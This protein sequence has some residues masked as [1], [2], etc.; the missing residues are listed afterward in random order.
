MTHITCRLTA[1][2]WDQLRI[3]TLGNGVWA[4]FTFYNQSRPDGQLILTASAFNQQWISMPAVQVAVPTVILHPLWTSSIVAHHLLDFMV[5]VKITEADASTICLDVPH[6]DYRCPSS[7]IPPFFYA[8][9]LFCRNLPNLS[10]LGTG[11]G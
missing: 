2:N 3:P 10:F 6:P 9:C 1:K 8:E 11:T 7:I 5:Q 4:T